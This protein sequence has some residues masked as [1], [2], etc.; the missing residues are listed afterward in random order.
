MDL[1][2]DRNSP[3]DLPG[4]SEVLG[5]QEHVGAGLSVG[6]DR[7]RPGDGTEVVVDRVRPGEEV[8]FTGWYYNDVKPVI[9]RWNALDGPVLATVAPD[10]FGAVHNH[11]RSIAG[12]LPTTERV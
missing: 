6:R 11:F 2:P 5:S 9:I 10:T 4:R 1:R 8:S 3:G 12:T 7:Q